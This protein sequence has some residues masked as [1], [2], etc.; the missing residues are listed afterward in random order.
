MPP[1]GLC[2]LDSLPRRHGQTS[3][4]IMCQSRPS[5]GG[6]GDPGGKSGWMD[7]HVMQRISSFSLTS[8][9]ACLG[10]W[11]GP[12]KAYDPKRAEQSLKM[13]DATNTSMDNEL[14]L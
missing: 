1:R 6:P 8:S 2:I 10:Q 7:V 11:N 9:S 5:L 4:G 12:P 13:V 3:T 14:G